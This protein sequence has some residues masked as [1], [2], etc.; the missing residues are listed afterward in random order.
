MEAYRCF[1]TVGL[2]MRCKNYCGHSVRIT[3]V[4]SYYFYYVKMPKCH[5]SCSGNPKK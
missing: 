2:G 3:V 4:S 1:E 5:K